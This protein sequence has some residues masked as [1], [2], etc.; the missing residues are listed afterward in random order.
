[1]GE[2]E[3]LKSDLAV[4]AERSAKKSYSWFWV[5]VATGAPCIIFIFIPALW[6]LIIFLLPIALLARSWSN[7][8]DKDMHRIEADMA[9]I[10]SLIESGGTID[11][12]AEKR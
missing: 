12:Y 2:L 5:M 11:L 9:R 1:M 7:K 6:V 10:E 3:E 4:E 8:H